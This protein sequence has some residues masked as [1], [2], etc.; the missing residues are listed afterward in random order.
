MVGGPYY[1]VFLGQ[2][3]GISF[4]IPLYRKLGQS[5]GFGADMNCTSASSRDGS[6]HMILLEASTNEGNVS[7]HKHA[8]ATRVQRW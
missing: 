5:L 2:K 7:K 6:F 3:D 1:N 8:V 4:K